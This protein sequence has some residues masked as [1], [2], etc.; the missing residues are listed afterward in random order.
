MYVLVNRRKW[1]SLHVWNF[2][3]DKMIVNLLYKDI[4]WQ[5]VGQTMGEM[6][7]WFY[8]ANMMINSTLMPFK[9]GT[10]AEDQRK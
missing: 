10:G 3:N 2:Q 7:L 8:G 1:E 4:Y 6:V 5:Q 9:L